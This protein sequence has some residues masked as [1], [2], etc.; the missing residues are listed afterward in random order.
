ML[1]VGLTLLAV[2]FAFYFLLSFFG[3]EPGPNPLWHAW[4]LQ[5]VLGTAII[6]TVGSLME[7]WRLAGGGK[8]LAQMV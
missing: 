5:A 6:I 7:Y 3:G 4:S 1:A 2:N 8:S